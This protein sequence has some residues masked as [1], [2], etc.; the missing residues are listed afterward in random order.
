MKKIPLLSLFVAIIFI[1]SFFGLTPKASAFN[2]FVTD[3]HVSDGQTITLPITGTGYNV[4]WGDS[5]TDNTTYTTSASHTYATAG[6]YRVSVDGIFDSINF[7]NNQG[8]KDYIYNIHQWGTAQWSSLENAFYGCSNLTSDASDA[9]DLSH[10]T[11]TSMG[12]IFFHASSFNGNISSWNVSHVTDMHYMFLG[13]SSFN[14]DISSWDVSSVTTMEQMFQEAT[15]F[16]NGGHALTWTTNGG[17]HLVQNMHAMFLNASFFNQDISSWDVSSVQNMSSM[18][19][20]NQF[21]NNGGQALTWITGTGTHNVINMAGMFQGASAFNQNISSWDVS[22]VQNMSAM[23]ENSSSFNQNI[24]SWDVSSVQNMSDMFYSGVHSSTFNNGGVALT[25]GSHTSS[26]QN[27]SDMFG[28]ASAFNQDISSWD[29]SSVTNMS[30]M[31]TSATAFSII[32]YDKLLTAWSLLTLQHGTV[33]TLDAPNTHYCNATAGRNTLTSAPNNWVIN[34]AGY[35]CTYT[36]TGPNSGPVNSQSINF[37]I[38]PNILFTGDISIAVSGGGLDTTITKTF[39]NSATPQTF[40]IT[41]TDGTSLVTLI[42]T[43]SGSLTNPSTSYYLPEATSYTVTGPTSGK[44]HIQSTFT[45]TTNG[46]NGEG[47]HVIVTPSGGGLSTPITVDIFGYSHSTTFSVT[48]TLTGTL[49][50]AFRNNIELLNS[51]NFTYRVTSSS[52]GGSVG[53]GGGG[54]GGTILPTAPVIT[55]IITQILNATTTPAVVSSTFP[56]RILI[57]GM[58]GD[59]VKYLQT[60]L[61]THGYVLA[62]TGPGSPGNEITRF[63]KLTKSAVI[64]FQTDHKLPTF[65]IV[66][67]MTRGIMKW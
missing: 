6:T 65:G 29:V 26:V 19:L 54:G 12:A 64:K 42:P 11:N 51:D 1:F 40:T 66:G 58:M 20:S 61:N 28:N 10:L 9:P 38:T 33:V 52:T 34:D 18:F 57:E 56:F 46:F 24:S 21:F 14:Q 3:W 13:A 22:S 43:S 15:L 62:T 67:K 41:P 47:S 49:I 27:M 37:T 7:L 39:S 50:F 59:D 45:I 53:G 25:W 5:T 31:L 16:N 30:N 8:D 35:L 44:A 36:L 2:P 55:P 23:F 60:Y 17:T 63:G 32:N 4:D 48:P